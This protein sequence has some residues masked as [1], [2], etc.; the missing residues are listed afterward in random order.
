MGIY[1]Y[2]GDTEAFRTSTAEPKRNGISW[3]YVKDM[4]Q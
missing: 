4:S 1:R 2:F 3:E